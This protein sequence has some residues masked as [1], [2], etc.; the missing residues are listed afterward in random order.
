MTDIILTES[1]MLSLKSIFFSQAEEILD[2]LP[3]YIMAIEDRP[4]EYNWK[5]LKRAFHTLKGDSKTLGFNSLSTFSHKV[6]DLIAYL[7]DKELERTSID[8]LLDCVDAFEIFIEK[9]SKGLE[10]DM[11]EIISKIESFI[12]NNLISCGRNETLKTDKRETRIKPFLRIE[13][14]RIDRIMNLVGELVIGRSMLSQ[15]IIESD[16]LKKDSII[17]DL[18]SL[19]S[20]FERTISDLQNSVM[21]VRMLPIDLVFRRFPKFVRE[22]S[23]EKG[24]LI[25]LKIEGENTEL[26]KGLTDVL[27]EP[28][29]HIIRNAVDHGIETPQERASLGK[30]EEGHIYLRAFHQGNQIV[31]E[32]EDDGKGIDTDKL[33]EKAIQKGLISKEEGNKMTDRESLDLIFLSG[34]STSDTVTELS[35]RGIGMDIVNHVVESLRGTLEINSVKDRGTRVTLKLPLTLAIINSLL[36]R[37]SECI[38]AI[39]LTSVTEIIRVVPEDLETI[40]GYPFLRHRDCMVPL[41]SMNGTGIENGKAFAIILHI[42]QMKAGLIADNIIGEEELVIKSLDT[43]A[44]S[45]LSI[46]ASILGNGKVILILDPLFLIKKGQGN[47]HDTRCK[48]QIS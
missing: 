21:K 33:K 31:L 22:L 41:I 40:S 32:V 12:G 45:N 27:G 10:P 13:P 9:L 11:S 42:S 3:R 18:E 35:G 28:I 34:F 47:M 15:I 39:P 19:N 38:F 48:I 25:K 24:K 1:D 14:E 30:K 16:R 2:N 8:L 37:Y 5:E 26:D 6:E 29:L 36:F 46:G 43:M 20:N 17:S 4:D 7:N 23:D 44:S